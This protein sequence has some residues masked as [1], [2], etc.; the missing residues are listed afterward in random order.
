VALAPWRA[1]RPGAA[2]LRVGPPTEEELATCPFCEGREDQTPPEVLAIAPPGREPDTPGWTV[3]V[4]PNKYPA[5]AHHEVVI[6]SARHVRS[7]ADLSD[8]EIRA[9][10]EAWHLRREAAQAAGFPYVQLVLNEGRDA[11]ASLPHSHSQLVWLSDVPPLVADESARMDAG[12]PLCELVEQERSER[13]RL[14]A[15]E[16]GLVAFAPWASRSPYE[17]WVAGTHDADG[18]DVDFLKTALGLVVRAVRR[19]REAEGAV[20]LNVWLHDAGHP[21]IELVP[22]FSTHAGFELGAGIYLNSL[23]PE[24]AAG[25]LRDSNV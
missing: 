11:G 2:T 22:R 15:E 4:V 23:A 20:P 25:R 7:I 16:G 14:V 6:H 13:L 5:F 12:C 21:H 3:R 8:E 10:A 17:V 9:V 24:E 1:S 18:F 19:L